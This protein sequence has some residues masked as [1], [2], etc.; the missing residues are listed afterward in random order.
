MSFYDNFSKRNEIS[1][2]GKLLVNKKNNFYINLI[3][4]YLDNKKEGIRIL[5]IGPGKGYFAQAC[6]NQGLNYTGIEAN[7]KMSEKLTKEGFNIYNKFVPPIK[8]NEKFD[9]I[10]MD[11]VFEHMKNRTMAI[12][13]LKDCKTHL[14]RNGLLL[15]SVPDIRFSKEDFFASDYTHNFPL[16]LYSLKQ[17]FVDFNFEIKYSNVRTLFLNGHFYS[18]LIQKTTTLLYSLGI[19]KLIFKDRAYK[20]KNLGNASCIVIGEK[21]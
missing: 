15:I 6:K 14:E 19:I 1:E 16:S 12:D 9:V 18:G 4:K 5:E 2:I 17:M 7:T 10:F 20:I 3:L 11:Q 13:L 21:S 8:L